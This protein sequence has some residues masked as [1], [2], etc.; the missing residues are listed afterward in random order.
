[1]A[2][3]DLGVGSGSGCELGLLEPVS[4]VVRSGVKSTG[5]KSCSM[6]STA[7]GPALRAHRALALASRVDDEAECKFTKLEAN[8]AW[9]C[10]AVGQC[11]RVAKGSDAGV[12]G[13]VANWFEALQTIGDCHAGDVLH[14]L[15][16]EL[17]GNT[18]PQRTT[19]AWREVGGRVQ[20]VAVGDPASSPALSRAESGRAV[21]LVYERSFAA[22]DVHLTTLNGL[23]PSSSARP[24]TLRKAQFRALSAMAAARNRDG[25]AGGT[26]ASAAGGLAQGSFATR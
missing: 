9:C 13:V 2:E 10:E 4:S 17:A 26:A 22:T 18:E 3:R 6:P 7:H 19:M 23:Q 11:G 25:A 8:T 1:M 14:A 21:L 12:P 20:V 24:L 16:P 5:K 15:V